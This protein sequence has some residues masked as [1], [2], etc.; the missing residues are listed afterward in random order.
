[1]LDITVFTKYYHLTVGAQGQV[2]VAKKSSTYDVNHKNPHSPTKKFFLECKL[3][4]L[5]H[6]LTL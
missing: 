1:M 3:Q 2:K 6:L 5:P 4:D